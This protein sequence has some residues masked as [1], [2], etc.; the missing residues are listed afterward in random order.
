MIHHELSYLFGKEIV[1]QFDERRRILDV[2]L[3]YSGKSLWLPTAIYFSALIEFGEVHVFI[4]MNISRRNALINEMSCEGR[5]PKAHRYLFFW[6]TWNMGVDVK[7]DANGTVLRYRLL[8]PEKLNFDHHIT[9]FRNKC[10]GAFHLSFFLN[11]SFQNW[12]T[13]TTLIERDNKFEIICK[14]SSV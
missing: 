11:I 9:T 5:F 7:I 12:A 4:S 2:R 3:S 14:I 10:S 8:T 6:N 1:K 13:L